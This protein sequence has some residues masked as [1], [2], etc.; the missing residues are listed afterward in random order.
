MKRAALSML[1]LLCAITCQ[2]QYTTITGTFEDA[3]G[4][5]VVSGQVIFQPSDGSGNNLAFQTSNGQTIKTPVTCAI[6]AGSVASSCKVADTSATNPLNVCFKLSAKNLATNQII[7]GPFPCV[8]PTGSSYSL[9]AYHPI[10]APLA[11]VSV[12]PG[13]STSA[14]AMDGTASAG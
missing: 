3:A 6:T 7:W 13:A 8:Q 11:M 10:V 4:N 1:L 14:P 5:P 9:N 12:V 2:A